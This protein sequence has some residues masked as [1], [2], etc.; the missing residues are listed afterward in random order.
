MIAN[1]FETSTHLLRVSECTTGFSCHMVTQD[2]TLSQLFKA[3]QGL[4]AKAS[5]L[6]DGQKLQDFKTRFVTAAKSVTIP[7]AFYKKLIELMLEKIELLLDIKVT[8]IL[9]KT[10][11]E[12]EDLQ[13]DLEAGGEEPEEGGEDGLDIP[14]VEHTIVSE[15]NPSL[16]V[17]LGESVDLGELKFTIRVEFVLAGVVLKVKQGKIIHVNIGSCTAKGELK[18]DDL[19]LLVLENTLVE[20]PNWIDFTKPEL[21]ESLEESE[22]MREGEIEVSAP[23]NS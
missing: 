3:K 12:S 20:L 7:D 1:E 18:W 8:D 9:V 19:S 15:H 21:P 2:L 16:Q 6:S 13:E 4:K 10:W 11:G 5:E 17:K 23:T 22:V 14:L